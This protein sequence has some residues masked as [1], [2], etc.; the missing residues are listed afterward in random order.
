[1]LQVPTVAIEQFPPTMVKEASVDGFTAE[2][3]EFLEENTKKK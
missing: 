1:M 2:A 3:P